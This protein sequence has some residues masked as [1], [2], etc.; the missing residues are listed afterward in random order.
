MKHSQHSLTSINLCQ[1]LAIYINIFCWLS[2]SHSIYQPHCTF[3]NIFQPV[4]ASVNTHQIVLASIDSFDC[5]QPILTSL[6]FCP[7]RSTS[8]KFLSPLKIVYTLKPYVD[9]LH[10][11]R[12]D[13]RRY[14]S[15]RMIDE[16][17]WLQQMRETLLILAL[18]TV[19]N[20]WSW[21]VINYDTGK[22]IMAG[23]WFEI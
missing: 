5:Y 18:P 17:I 20:R 10:S 12:N 8:I 7:P 19:F 23:G 15:Q 14:C 21:K 22:H 9:W 4:S 6:H 1:T 11:I 3:I 16:Y 13:R 2:T